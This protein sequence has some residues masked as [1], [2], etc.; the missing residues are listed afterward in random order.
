[1][2]SDHKG[3]PFY[4]DM[5]LYTCCFA[6]AGQKYFCLTFQRVLILS[7][8]VSSISDWREWKP[9]W[10]IWSRQFP[11]HKKWNCPTLPALA[12]CSYSYVNWRT[13]NTQLVRFTAA[14]INSRRIILSP[15]FLKI[16]LIKFR[17][18]FLSTPNQPSVCVSLTLKSL[19]ASD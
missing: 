8:V 18:I 12:T 17:V 2:Y 9:F 6:G 19:W 3:T 13:K 15:F 11:E 7:P 10:Q 1:M 4:P 5:F 14:S 16:V